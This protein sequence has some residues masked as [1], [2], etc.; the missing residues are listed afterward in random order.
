MNSRERST[1]DAQFEVAT[2]WIVNAC[3]DDDDASTQRSILN[4][5]EVAPP[6]K[7]KVSFHWSSPDILLELSISEGA[8]EDEKVEPPKLANIENL[9]CRRCTQN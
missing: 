8:N 5:G 1:T 2:C 9:S 3:Q 4:E 7:H 6:V